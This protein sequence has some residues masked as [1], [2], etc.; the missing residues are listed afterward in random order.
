[1]GDAECGEWRRH[2]HWTPSSPS[3]SPRARSWQPRFHHDRWPTSLRP[4]D[5]Q[6]LRD[7]LLTSPSPSPPAPASSSSK[8]RAEAVYARTLPPQW[9]SRLDSGLKAAGELDA[10]ASSKRRASAVC[11]RTLPPQWAS[12]LDSGL[13]AAGELDASASSKRRPWAR[14]AVDRGARP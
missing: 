3:S 6:N 14:S 1:M 12:R 13:K 4:V 2:D 8:R 7:G 11:A 10:S 5:L 9:A